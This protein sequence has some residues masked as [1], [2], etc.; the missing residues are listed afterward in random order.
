MVLTGLKKG[1]ETLIARC[2]LEVARRLYAASL[3]CIDTW[4]DCGQITLAL[5]DHAAGSVQDTRV[6]YGLAGF[7]VG[8]CGPTASAT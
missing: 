3:A 5:D 7:S 1:S 6:E 4:R 8:D 2:G